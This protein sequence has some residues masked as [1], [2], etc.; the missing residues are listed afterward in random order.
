MKT[1][2]YYVCIIALLGLVRASVAQCVEG[3][4]QQGEG[5]FILPGGNRYVGQFQR[6]AMEGEG[7]LY[8]TDGSRYLGGFKNGQPSG[9]GVRIFSDGSR[10]EGYWQNGRLQSAVQLE[11]TP[12]AAT[13]T[14]CVS[15]DCQN[16]NGTYVFTGG[17]IYT[18]NFSNGEIHGHGICYYPDGSTYKGDWV[19]RYPEGYGV[20]TWPDGRSRSGQWHLGQPTDE[21]GRYVDALES[22]ASAAN[23][24]IAIQSGCLRGNCENGRG[25]YAYPDGSRYEGDFYQGRPHGQGTF[26]YP[27]GDQ[28]QG[29]FRQGL[30][31]GSGALTYANGQRV[32]GNWIEG[33]LQQAAHENTAATGC[34]SGD[35][36]NGY[37]VYVFRQGDRYTG[38]FRNNLPDGNGEV[39]YQNGE[40]YVGAM[41]G[42]AFH[43]YGT[44]Y[45]NDGPPLRGQWQNGVFKS[46]EQLAVTSTPS[47]RANQPRVWVLIVGV[48]VYRHM[49]VLRFPDDDAY[50]L[51]AFFKSPEGGAIPDDQI[52][53]LIDE[54]ATKDNI[55]RQM[56]ELFGQAAPNDL[57][58]LYFSG[59]GL[60]GAFL[61]ID[62]DGQN[63]QLFHT[64]IK[65][66]LA[67]SR[68]K[69]QL[70]LADACH[71]G[72]LLAARGRQPSQ[73]LS[74]YYENLARARPGSALIMS[75]KS[76]ETSLESSG[77]RQG[78]FSHF[79]L[80][81]LKGQA[82]ANGNQIVTVQELFQY[83]QDNV[84]Q[85]TGSLQ[86][87]VIEGDFDPNMP[88]S[89]IR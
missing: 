29:G 16:G 14:G 78:V 86:S 76:E 87:P 13:R 66:L 28:Y 9:Q 38:Y 34:L 7:A 83:V 63:N 80:R 12:R 11:L 54:D 37:G 77:L 52:Q 45:R 44:F 33:A 81:G 21:Q 23:T 69:N 24:S 74:S 19:R 51:F 79:L 84:R 47:S 1:R 67:S 43:G 59:H 46:Q 41:S 65:R 68:A 71:S 60:P 72:S 36:Q 56:R 10:Q 39:I 55:T 27:N 3:N 48:S 58:V 50:R 31:H 32:S 70:I 73:V 49:P 75:S 22:A 18:G 8:Y 20:K 85:Y 53:V 30:R 62:Y 88:V 17:A 25:Y 40:R 89:V 64:E 61:P 26:S 35:C 82:D 2:R 6:G 15:G 5:V 4:C 57:I 42:G